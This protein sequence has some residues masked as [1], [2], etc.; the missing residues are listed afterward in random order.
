MFWN[1][2]GAIFDPVFYGR[3]HARWQYIAV[4][5]DI[6]EDQRDQTQL[7]YRRPPGN[8]R[9]TWGSQKRQQWIVFFIVDK[10]S[11]YMDIIHVLITGVKLDL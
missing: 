4:W 3:C 9:I 11:S 2:L 10:R 7:I 6:S 1:L 8:L 5:A